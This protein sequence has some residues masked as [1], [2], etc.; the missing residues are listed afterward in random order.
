VLWRLDAVGSM[1]TP[2]REHL[3]ALGV[4]R[5]AAVMQPRPEPAEA[6][7]CLAICH[8]IDNNQNNQSKNGER[9]RDL[10]LAMGRNAAYEAGTL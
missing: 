1:A 2:S 8:S 3:L 5:H 10:P 9:A 6:G 7:G 4:A